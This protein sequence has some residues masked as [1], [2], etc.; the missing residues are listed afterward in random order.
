MKTNDLTMVL[1]T[2]LQHSQIGDQTFLHAM[3][4]LIVTRGYQYY[5]K[6]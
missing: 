4:G 5:L 1:L 2:G 6:N 3:Q